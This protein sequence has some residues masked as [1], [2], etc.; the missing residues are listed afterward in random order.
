[1]TSFLI[2]QDFDKHNERRLKMNSIYINEKRFHELSNGII[3]RQKGCHGKIKQP[4][5]TVFV[6]KI[7]RT[8]TVTYYDNKNRVIDRTFYVVKQ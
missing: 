2:F 1:M 7:N 3:P 5:K 6:D 4:R 8:V